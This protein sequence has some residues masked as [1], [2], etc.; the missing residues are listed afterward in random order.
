VAIVVYLDT[1]CR[2]TRIGASINSARSGL[3]GRAKPRI[4]GRV[5]GCRTPCVQ[6]FARRIG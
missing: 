5:I 2:G 3:A 4:I 1:P 6:T